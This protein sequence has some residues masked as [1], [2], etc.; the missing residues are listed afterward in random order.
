V[1]GKVATAAA[2]VDPELAMAGEMAA[3]VVL[4]RTYGMVQEVLA[5]IAAMAAAVASVHRAPGKTV[6]VGVEVAVE[7]VVDHRLPTEAGSEFSDKVQTVREVAQRLQQLQEESA[8]A[9]DQA[10]VGVYMVVVA[11]PMVQYLH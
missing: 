4:P 2:T 5:V 10:G 3:A 9:Q 1:A 6:Q 7:A 11:L 8:V